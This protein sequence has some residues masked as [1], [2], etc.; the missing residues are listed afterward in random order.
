MNILVSA[1]LLGM[2]C[3][4]DGENNW[5]SALALLRKRHCLVPVCPEIFGGLSTPREPAEIREGKVYNRQ[6]EEITANF[7]KGAAETLKLAK[8]FGCQAA[9]LKERSPSCGCGVIYDGS[10][11]GKKIPGDG[12]TAAL[13]KRHGIQVIGESKIEFLADKGWEKETC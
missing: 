11:S 13:L 1:C 8:F 2:N 3:R 12:I 7:T 10:F 6:G 5:N 9:V 4:Y